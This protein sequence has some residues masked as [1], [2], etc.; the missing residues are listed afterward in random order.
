MKRL[1]LVALVAC[2]SP[3]DSDAEGPRGV[4]YITIGA[5]AV[6]T[7][8]DVAA[9]DSATMQVVDSNDDAAVIA[10]DA[11]ELEPLSQQLHAREG[12]CGGYMV[13]DSLAD[14][15]DSLSP[16]AE[17]RVDYSLDHAALVKDVLPALDAERI[18]TTIAELQGMTSRYY[19]NDSGA[20]ASLWLRDRWRS[21]TDREDVT[22]ELVDHGY[23]QK[24]V[25]MTIP[26]TSRAS[27][28]VVIGG[29]LD[30]INM[31]GTNKPAPGADDDA[32]GIAT[33]TEVARVLLAK[34]FRPERTIKFM[35]YAAEEVGLRGSLSIA[36]DYT[37]R[38]VDVVG[39]LQL[40]MTNYQG[41]DK[42]IWLITDHTSAAQNEFLAKLIEAYVGATYDYDKCGYAC[43]D[44]ASWH[45]H[46]VPASMPF[47]SR[48][49]Q[50]N[51]SIHSVEDTL[52]VSGNNAQH[53]VKFARLAAAY[54]IELGKGDVG[55]VQ[56]APE[57]ESSSHRW[58]YA[59]LGLLALG[60]LARRA[61]R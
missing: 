34:D 50:Y 28:V 38:K 29:H 55:T 21:F 46:G 15:L 60:A 45:R 42:D 57:P 12:R 39:V 16:P 54:A 44:H 3:P 31:R 25:V 27:E 32:S 20:A 41:S 19:R 7:A 51:G 9:E 56:S 1:A 11:R 17:R 5:D 43:S 40:D 35:A 8:A 30:S 18:R 47:E 59:L 4:R 10:I 48:F 6:A 24:S 2:S 13:H 58:V 26:G 49:R 23:P 36:R 33:L 22:I 14:A 61:V 53:A 52:E 37:K